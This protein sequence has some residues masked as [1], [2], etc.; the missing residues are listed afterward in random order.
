VWFSPRRETEFRPDAER[1]FRDAGNRS[2]L[3][4]ARWHVDLRRD[5]A[6]EPRPAIDSPQSDQRR[7]A[8]EIS[9]TAAIRGADDDQPE[10]K[11][12]A[13]DGPGPLYHA[14][15]G[16]DDAARHGPARFD[17]CAAADGQDD[18]A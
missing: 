2:A 10:S 18:P 3:R 5:P 17:C 11:D 9:G 16:F 14:R 15:H 1:Y 4:V 7:R 13:R 6:R 12:Q 8:D